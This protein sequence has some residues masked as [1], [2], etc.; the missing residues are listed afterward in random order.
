[1]TIF[2]LCQEA[3][4]LY[5]PAVFVLWFEERLLVRAAF[6]LASILKDFTYKVAAELFCRF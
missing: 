3:L 5:P 4:L 1:M 6:R 2:A